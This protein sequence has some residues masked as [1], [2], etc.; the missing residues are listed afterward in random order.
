MTKSKKAV[1][2][3]GKE[4]PLTDEQKAIAKPILDN[5]NNMCLMSAFIPGVDKPVAVVCA[6]QLQADRSMMFYPRFVV[7]TDDMFDLIKPPPETEV[8]KELD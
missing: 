3:R 5:F 8:I 6:F 4:Q 2:E 7:V 1:V